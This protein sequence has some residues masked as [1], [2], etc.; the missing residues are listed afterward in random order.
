MGM[1]NGLMM[2]LTPMDVA[3]KGTESSEEEVKTDRELL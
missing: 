1:S 3:P 2:D